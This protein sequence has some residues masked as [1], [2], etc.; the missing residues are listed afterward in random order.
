MSQYANSPGNTESC[1]AELAVS[2]P[3]VAETIA[4]TQCTNPRRDG[5]AE[6]PGK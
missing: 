4:C 2:F 6:W 1:F 5:Q 3:V